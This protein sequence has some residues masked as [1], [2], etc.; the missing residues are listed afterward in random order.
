MAKHV[1]VAGSGPAGL[2]AALTA[3]E[4]GHKV[5]IFE[6]L[7]GPG[8]KLLASGAGKCNFTNILT[9]EDMAGH[10]APEQRNFVRFALAGFTPQE[11]CS[12]FAENNIEHVLVDNFYCFPA[13]GKASD[14]LQVFLKKITG[15]H[16][17][18]ICQTPITD[19]TVKD[20]LICAVHADNKTFECDYMIAAGGGP[21]YPG[22]GGR[23]SL[24]KILRKYNVSMVP[25][26]PALCGLKSSEPWLEQLSGIVLDDSRLYLNK[27]AFTRG[28]L[29]FTGRGLS[30]PAA[31][32]ISGRVAKAV[33]AGEKV[34]LYADFRADMNTRDWRNIFDQARRDNGKRLMRNVLAQYLPQALTSALTTLA[35]A[36][37]ITAANCSREQIE[38]LLIML[39]A[40][41]IKIDQTESWDKAMASTGGMARSKIN[42]R[43]MQSREFDNLYC[44]G[45]F[46]DVDGPCGGYNIQWALSSGRLAGLLKK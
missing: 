25:R 9:A 15:Y 32:D 46:I 31:L 21:G 7:P 39:T 19:L 34:I 17:K 37:D 40:C 16:G 38:N 10:F 4:Q 2:M 27:K 24:D 28:N 18:I 12:F 45:E 33:A 3:A 43:T 44:A 35:G 5:T 6:S 36:G 1:V 29:L 23:G 14:I 26:T 41:P 11:T 30:G 42:P 20:N 22:L 8:R 13:S